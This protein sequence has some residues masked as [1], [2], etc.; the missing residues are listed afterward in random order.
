MAVSCSVIF[1]LAAMLDVERSALG[2]YVLVVFVNACGC[3][4]VSRCFA[5]RPAKQMARRAGGQRTAHSTLSYA[6]VGGRQALRR[7]HSAATGGVNS[8]TNAYVQ[9]SRLVRARAY[10]GDTQTLLDAKHGQ[11]NS[12]AKFAARGLDRTSQ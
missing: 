6:A 7:W 4:A 9:L 5:V 2:G 11:Q 3:E 8:F 12:L 1:D 10:A